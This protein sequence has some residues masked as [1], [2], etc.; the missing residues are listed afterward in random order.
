MTDDARLHARL[1]WRSRRGMRE[2]DELLGR[3]LEKAW[4]NADTSER[5]TFE[6]LLTCEDTDLWLW[7]MGRA[8]PPDDVALAGL[9]KIIRALP[10][11]N[12]SGQ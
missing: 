12:P 1:R 5:A 6:R 3:Y 11:R 7:L 10:A 4:P 9:V 8:D 2:L